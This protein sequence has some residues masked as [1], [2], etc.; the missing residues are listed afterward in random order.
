VCGQVFWNICIDP[1]I[2]N[3]NNLMEVHS[4]IAY[5]DDIAI[6]INGNA[7]RILEDKS[8]IITRQIK[9]GAIKINY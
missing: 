5:A 4:V 3:L 9:N 1:C 2:K 7:R 6:I 8:S